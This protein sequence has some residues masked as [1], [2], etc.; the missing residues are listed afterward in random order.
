MNSAP[1]RA[2]V[3][4]SPNDL[5]SIIEGWCLS[6]TAE[7]FNR[8]LP[9]LRRLARRRAPSLPA[10]LHDEIVHETWQL[11]IARGYDSFVAAGVDADR[12]LATVLRNAVEVVKA[13][14]RPAGAK[15][16]DRSSVGAAV[17]FSEG[18]ENWASKIWFEVEQ[19]E[20]ELRLD[21]ERIAASLGGPVATALALIV[22]EGMS[23]TDAAADVGMSRQTL[24]RRLISLRRAA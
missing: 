1:R 22:N 13:N 10:D 21:L 19:A 24:S 18:A 15:S 8:T 4:T 12:Y 5:L 2:R 7:T 6:A 17:D 23:V 3:R 9:W 14:Y 11:V 16:R 20:L